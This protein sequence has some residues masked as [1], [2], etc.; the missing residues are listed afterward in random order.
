MR[1]GSES[2]ML[3]SSSLRGAQ[4]VVLLF[5]AMSLLGRCGS[6][7]GLLMANAKITEY[8]WDVSHQF[9]SPDC[10]RKLAITIN[11]ET[12]GPTIDAQQGDTVVVVVNNSLLTENAAIHWHGI[13]QIGTPWSDGTEG[14][15]QCPIMPGDSFVYRFVPGTYLYHAHYGMQMSAGLYGVIR[16][17]VPDGTVEPFAYDF[18]H[19]L[20]LNDWWHQSTY[21]QAAGLSAVPFVWIEEPQSLLINGRGQFNC[22]LAGATDVCHTNAPECSPYVLS[23]VPGKTYRLRIASLTA[24]SALNFEVEGHNMTV[25]EADGHYVKPFVV[26]NLNIYSGETYSVLIT[27]DQDPSRNYW[28]AANVIARQ[29]RTP[30]GTGILNYLHG[31]PDKKPPTATPAG[32]MWNDTEY[33]LAQSTAL[34]AHPDHILPPP[35]TADRMILL[36]NTQNLIDGHTRWA[37]NNVSFNFPHT[38]YL[39][40]MKQNLSDVFDE[41]P[42]PETYDYKHYDIYSPSSNPNATV[43][44]SIYRFE[45]NS[46]VDVVLQSANILK[47]NKSETH[48]WHMHGHD[49]WVLA[50]GM[51]RFDPDVDTARFNLVDPIL[52]NTVDLQPFGWTAIRFKA[53][54]PGVWAFH[55]HVESHFYMGM[56]VVFEEGIDR[57]GELPESIMGCGKSKLPKRS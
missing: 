54:N 14:V 25:V 36:L 22:A 38:P 16:V 39:I 53:D 9:K 18:D 42:A 49:F 2:T 6:N 55:C 29:P 35:A 37:L 46:T 19:S 56:G 34:R 21:E 30:A 45:F 24:L 50:H 43:G 52:K 26:K 10:F 5:A 27:A 40:A 28:L 7:G 15:T 31:S 47:P 23:V 20:L 33:R 32:P 48:P 13:R 11:G 8:R 1:R 12:P 57:V 51:G 3:L 44:T 4:Q 41:R 17:T